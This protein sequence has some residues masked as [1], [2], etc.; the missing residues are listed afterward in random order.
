MALFT[1]SS[2]THFEGPHQS[3]QVAQA[4]VSAEEADVAMIMIHGRGA[5]AESILE[6][7]NEF[8]TDKK[9][10]FRAP[11]ASGFTW[12]P[13]SFLAPTK[14]NEP[15][16]SSGLQQIFNIISELESAGIPKQKIYLLGFS[17]G[18]CL[19]SEYIA[20]HPAKYAGLIALS[21]G[22][23]GNQVKLENYD[24]DMQETPV[25]MGCSDVDPH[26]PKERVDETE[27]VFNKL[28]A[29]TVKK[30]Y[31]GMGHLVNQDEIKHI[32]GMLST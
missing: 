31:P 4:G 3:Q 9:I 22:L 12:Y 17:Q 18:A 28:G 30:I 10:A 16:L 11:Q 25:F 27:R 20:R 29:K 5:G 1:I 32:K 21:G 23:I 2:N 26:I 7:A 13:Y 24:G 6:L 15:G 8:D 19:A 14:Q